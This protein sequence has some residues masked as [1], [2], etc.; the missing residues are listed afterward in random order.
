MSAVT[1]PGPAPTAIDAGIREVAIRFAGP[2]R[3]LAGTVALPHG[4]GPFPAAVLVSGSGPIDRDSNHPRMRLDVV[5][6][7]AH[8]LAQAGIA[9]LR[10]DKRGVG[11]SRR[12]RDGTT[13]GAG[14]WRRAGLHDNSA[15]AAAAMAALAA[16]DEVDPDAV[17]LIGHSEGAVLV[18]EVAAHALTNTHGPKPAGVVLLAAAAAPGD[19][20][21]RWQAAAI[22]PTLPAPVRAILRLTRTDLV[23]KVSRNHDR[24]RRTTGDVARV[25]GAKLN[26]KWFREYLDY[27]PRP[28]MRRL[29]VPVLAITGTKDLQVDPGDLVEIARLV[30]GPVE[31]W[32]APDVSHLL[33]VQ[34]GPAS[35]R[36]YKKEIR[37]PVDQAVLRRVTDW[38]NHQVHQ[39]SA[40]SPDWSGP[41][42]THA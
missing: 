10:Y 18:T 39:G 8:A 17:F 35:L 15:D 12:L 27:D 1:R 13:E 37:E 26:A 14:A 25:G 30:P 4:P 5:R 28:D 40:D 6:Q 7:L 23:A 38:L 31:T 36:A 21:L 42:A 11:E 3:D 9:S 16:R 24:I 34:P 20:V 33:R 41:S 29:D 22:A 32:L 19:A 2:D